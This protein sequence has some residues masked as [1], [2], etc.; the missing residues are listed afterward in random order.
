VANILFGDNEELANSELVKRLQQEHEVMYVVDGKSMLWELS[1][2]Q[3]KIEGRNYDLVI[4]DFDLFYGQAPLIKK[5]ELFDNNVATY[6]KEGKAPVMMIVE[7]KVANT[8]RS[9][10]REKNFLQIERPYT[11][12]EVVE[13]V[14]MVLL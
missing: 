5:M 3:K 14:N 13:S 11:I 8:I 10:V 2:T 12:N 6:L 1:T 7:D 9:L 4:C